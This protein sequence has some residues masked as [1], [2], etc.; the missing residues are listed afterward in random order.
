MVYNDL[1]ANI[2]NSSWAKR[3]NSIIDHLGF[4]DIR[5]NFDVNINYLPLLKC[6]IRDQFIQEWN[7]SINSMPKLIKL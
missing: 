3:I 5:L 1:N 6:R 4:M 2:N 7:A